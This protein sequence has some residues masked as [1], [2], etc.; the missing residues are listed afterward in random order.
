[1]KPR[2]FT[3]FLSYQINLFEETSVNAFDSPGLNP[4]QD[5]FDSAI[6]CT[7]LTVTTSYI[8]TAEPNGSS[9]VSRGAGDAAGCDCG[10]AGDFLRA[11]NFSTT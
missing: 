6:R 7:L 10:A 9:A 11:A 1:M 3:P 8:E 2:G 4:L 5:H